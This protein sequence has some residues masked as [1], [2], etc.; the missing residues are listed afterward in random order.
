MKGL[1]VKYFIFGI[2]IVVVL[3]LAVVIGLTINL[4]SCCACD[5]AQGCCPCPNLEY[6]DLIIQHA[7]RTAGCLQDWIMMC[8]DF[9][10]DLNL[11]FDCLK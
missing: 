10:E 3:M 4:E 9:K 11:E 1:D 2:P 6:E 5:T 8:E 7:N